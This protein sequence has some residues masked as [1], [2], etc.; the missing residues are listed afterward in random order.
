LLGISR[1]GQTI[2]CATHDPLLV[3]QADDVLALD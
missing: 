1:Y 2:V 3:S